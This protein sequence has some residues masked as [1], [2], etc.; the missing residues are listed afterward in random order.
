[1]FRNFARQVFSGK[2]NGDW[3]MW[4]LKTQQVQDACFRSAR[5]GGKPMKLASKL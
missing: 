1:M 5:K 4:V 3:P 2:L